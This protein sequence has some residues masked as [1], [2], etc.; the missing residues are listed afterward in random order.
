[1]STYPNYNVCTLRSRC[2]RL[3]TYIP[4][5]YRHLSPGDPR[6]YRKVANRAIDVDVKYHEVP[7]ITAHNMYIY[8]DLKFT[9]NENYLLTY[10]LT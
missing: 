1:M 7:G 4:R 3:T 6:S 8:V 5:V 2:P 9:V 10:L